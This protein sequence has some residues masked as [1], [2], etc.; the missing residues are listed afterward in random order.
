VMT[1]SLMNA[2]NHDELTAVIAHELIRIQEKDTWASSLGA[3]LGS[4]VIKMAS[5]SAWIGSQKSPTSPTNRNFAMVLLAPFAAIV[6]RLMNSREHGFQ[7]DHKA[8][9]LC[10]HKE[11]LIS[12][13]KKLEENKSVFT[14]VEIYPATAPL[15]MI[16]PLKTDDKINALFSVHPSVTERIQSLETA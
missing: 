5:L 16:D 14:T 7:I 6:V 3:A 4:A 13:L 8:A 12:A 2:L 10:E 9:A 11:W 15:F 1:T